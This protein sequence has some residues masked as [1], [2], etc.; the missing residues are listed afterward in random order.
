MFKYRTVT[1]PEESRRSADDGPPQYLRELANKWPAVRGQL[2][3][4]TSKGPAF[5]GQLRAL[6]GKWPAVWRQLRELTGK[7]LAFGGQLRELANQAVDKLA[8]DRQ[9]KRDAQLRG[10]H[11]RLKAYLATEAASPRGTVVSAGPRHDAP[12]VPDERL[13]GE[14]IRGWMEHDALGASRGVVEAVGLQGAHR[15]S[16]DERRRL[17]RAFLAMLDIDPRAL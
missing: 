13:I 11:E 16:E 9:A 6:T 2:R 1:I 8:D 3:K 12:G 17:A 14:L 4:L 10:S 7:G 5:W 15:L